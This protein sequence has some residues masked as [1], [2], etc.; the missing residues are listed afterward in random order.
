MVDARQV[1]QMTDLMTA[2]VDWGT[3]KA[4]QAGRPAAGKTG[5]SQDFRDAWFVGFTADLVAGAWLGNDDGAP[6]KGVTGGGLPARLWGRIMRRAL[7]D[8]EPEPLPIGEIAQAR[9]PEPKPS[10]GNFIK[11]ILSDL[12]DGPDEPEE[13]EE[14]VRRRRFFGRD[15]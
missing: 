11:R 14:P 9:E 10:G 13:P 4:R 1:D 8:K 15:D 5:T 3:G 6:M 7:K 2:T 12:I